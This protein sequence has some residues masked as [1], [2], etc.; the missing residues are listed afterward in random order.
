MKYLLLLTAIIVNVV[1]YIILK[2]ISGRPH[3][4][5]WLIQFLA[6]LALAGCTTFLFTLALKDFNLSQAYPIFCGGSIA[7]IFIVSYFLFREKT[8]ILQGIGIITIIAGVYMVT[9]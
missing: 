6:G 2:S 9:R 8:S 4:F 5:E 3:N 1:S 7:L